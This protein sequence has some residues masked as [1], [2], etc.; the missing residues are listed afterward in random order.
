MRTDRLCSRQK[1]STLVNGLLCVALLVTVYLFSLGSSVR[2]FWHMQFGEP[3]AFR[4]PEP[5]RL[6]TIIVPEVA[7]EAALIDVQRAK[8]QRYTLFETRTNGAAQPSSDWYQ[9]NAEPSYTCIHEERVGPKGEGGKW[10]CNPA[11]LRHTSE[12]LVYSVGSMNDFR[13]EEAILEI[14]EDCEIHVFDHTVPNPTGKPPG[15]HFHPWGLD[16]V[17][18]TDGMLKSLADIVKLLGHEGRKMNIFK[19]DCEGCEWT[20]FPSWFDAKVS[21]DEILVEV[22][23]GTTQPAENPIARQF[24]QYLADRDYF[25]FHKEPNVQSSSGHELCLEY[26]FKHVLAPLLSPSQKGNY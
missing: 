16:S 20:T 25:I 6:S 19:I 22:H 5:A 11:R 14:S 8:L 21:I 10:I 7:S 2:R 9:E 18:E 3:S 23:G 17:T 24:M 12:C 4:E 13:F 15:V 1:N 26:G